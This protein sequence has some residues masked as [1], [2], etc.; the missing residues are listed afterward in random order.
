M[1]GGKVSLKSVR[2]HVPDAF[3]DTLSNQLKAAL[4]LCR[5]ILH[6]LIFMR[7]SNRVPQSRDPG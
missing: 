4:Q 7:A 1:A 3:V 2:W 6:I 5:I